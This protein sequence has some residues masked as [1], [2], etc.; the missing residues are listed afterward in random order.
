MATYIYMILTIIPFKKKQNYK[1]RVKVGCSQGFR[2]RGR[3]ELG[4][5]QGLPFWSFPL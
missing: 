5:A 3:D 1:N 4:G 2:E